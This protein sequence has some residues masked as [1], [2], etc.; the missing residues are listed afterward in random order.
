[1]SKLRVLRIILGVLV[2]AI[3]VI[4]M[5]IIYIPILIWL[6]TGRREE[7]ISVWDLDYWP[8]QKEYWKT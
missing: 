4:G 7:Y 2:Q 5:I 8:W 6:A 1:V 3:A